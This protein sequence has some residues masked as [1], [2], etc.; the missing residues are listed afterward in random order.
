MTGVG[1]GESP[2][3]PICGSPMVL[4]TAK[5]GGSKGKAFWGCERF[6]ACKGTVPAAGGQ[7]LGPKGGPASRR[8]E[9]SVWVTWLA[10]VMSGDVD[11][12]WR[13]WFLTQHELNKRNP[14]SDALLGRLEQHD[15][16]VQT[17]S[18]RL[19]QQRVSVT[20]E[21]PL[22][23]TISPPGVKLSGSV[24]L[25]ADDGEIALYEVK[26]GRARLSDQYQLLIY[27]YL[28]Q[29][30]HGVRAGKLILVYPDAE[31]LVGPLAPD[32]ETRLIAAL[33]TLAGSAPLRRVPG[34]ECRY[35]PITSVDCIERVDFQEDD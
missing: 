27:S 17:L 28:W 9:P 22:N 11:C 7:R 25:A 10:G 20:S 6:P 14:T 23:A 34:L 35:C 3:C 29:R 4:R 32:F 24:D 21:V 8:K 33:Q 13:P 5:S 1:L 12:L 26:T 31:V 19:S 30:V 18:A 16:L 2:T 15:Q